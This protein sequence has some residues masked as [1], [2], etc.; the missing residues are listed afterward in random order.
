MK[1]LLIELL[2]YET[3]FLVFYGILL[4]VN[5]IEKDVFASPTYWL[6]LLLGNV[7]FLAVMACVQLYRAYRSEKK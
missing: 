5:V 6:V 3:G 7:V 4:A 2:K 1:K